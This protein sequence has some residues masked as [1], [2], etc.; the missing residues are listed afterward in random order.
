MEAPRRY[1]VSPYYSFVTV[2]A[3]PVPSFAESLRSVWSWMTG[4]QPKPT[5]RE[6]AREA[7]LIDALAEQ[8]AEED[9]AD[10]SAP[11]E[12][13]ASETKGAENV[14]GT[15]VPPKASTRAQPKRRMRRAA[16]GGT[17]A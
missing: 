4:R 9:S 15:N 11:G 16:P 17:S 6:R 10:K 7:R 14:S 8:M 3:R 13:S 12:K 5:L 1:S 2:S